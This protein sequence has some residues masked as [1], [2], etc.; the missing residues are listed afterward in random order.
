VYIPSH[1]P[2]CFW[3]KA[4]T[5][6]GVT[7][8]Q[9]KGC[10]LTPREHAR[11]GAGAV[12]AIVEERR[13]PGE[14]ENP[15][16]EYFR[17]AAGEDSEGR[18]GGR[19]RRERPDGEAF[20]NAAERWAEHVVPGTTVGSMDHK[21][22]NQ[23]DDREARAG[24]GVADRSPATIAVPPED[25]LVGEAQAPERIGTRDELRAPG[26]HLEDVRSPS[27]VEHVRPLQEP[28]E[29]LA[30]LTIAD[31]AEAAGRRHLARN[32]P[33]AAAPTPKREVKRQACQ[34]NASDHVPAYEN[35]VSAHRFLHERADLYLFGGAQL[36]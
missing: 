1:S 30:V 18:R 26:R 5:H 12:H 33:H 27:G 14:A 6:S 23:G 29:R 36:L 9:L 4:D 3:S 25:T 31:E 16:A 35:G 28:R 13:R 7:L 32:A 20:V 21:R 17:C 2:I 19:V 10:T 22:M 34:V 8:T 24:G 11:H 15:P